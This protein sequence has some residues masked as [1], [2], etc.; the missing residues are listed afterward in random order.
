ME[1]T[2]L[3]H[4]QPETDVVELLHPS[5]APSQAQSGAAAERGDAAN[6][7]GS[8]LHQA[9]KRSATQCSAAKR[10]AG[11]KR[12]SPRRVSSTLVLTR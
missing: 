12:R 10:S 2:N 8:G 9:A 11:A 3:C 5:G 4:P 1:G 7:A 6:G